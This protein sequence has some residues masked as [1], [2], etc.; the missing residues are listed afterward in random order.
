MI[1]LKLNAPSLI[2]LMQSEYEDSFTDEQIQEIYT[3]MEDRDNVDTWTIDDIA[4]GYISVSYQQAA[5]DYG[6]EVE[7]D[8]EMDKQDK[9]A[10]LKQLVIDV[11]T[12]KSM[13]IES[14]DDC[15]LLSVDN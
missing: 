2:F 4:K 8:S 12:D 6:I 15:V 3:H 13:L 11:M 10:H 1:T 7:Y 9:I 5:T 14:Y